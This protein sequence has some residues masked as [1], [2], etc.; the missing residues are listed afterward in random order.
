MAAISG[1]F[2]ANFRFSGALSLPCQTVYH[3]PPV[4]PQIHALTHPSIIYSIISDFGDTIFKK[5]SLISR[6]L[7][8]AVQL[9]NLSLL[10]VELLPCLPELRYFKQVHGSFALLFC[11]V[12]SW[13]HESCLKGTA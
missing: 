5:K 12:L 6:K 7:S 10:Q 2:P 8:P 4:G 3:F 13:L 11:S 9:L 1:Q